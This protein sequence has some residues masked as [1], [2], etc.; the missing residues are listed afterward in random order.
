MYKRDLSIELIS[1]AKAYPVVTLIGPR[2]AGKSTLARSCFPEMPYL[3]LEDPEIRRYAVEDP[4][5]FLAQVPQGAILDE[6][7]NVP[8]LLSYIQVLVDEKKQNGQFILTGSHQLSLHGAISQSLAGRTAILTLLPLSIDELQ[9]NGFDLQAD[10]LILNGGYPRVYEQHLDPTRAYADYYRTYVQR[11][12]RQMIHVKDLNLFEKFVKL[13]AGRIGSIFSASSLANEVGVSNN[14][15]NNWLSI[16][17]ASFIIFRLQP[18]FESFGKRV[19]KSPK[20]YFT[21]VGLAAYLLDIENMSQL[22]RDPLRGALFENL[23][24]LEMIKYRL[25]QGAAPN[26]YYYRD[27]HKN[28][29]DLVVKYGHEL[30]PVEIKSAETFHRDFLKAVKFFKKVTGDRSPRGYVVYAGQHTQQ[31]QE[32]DVINYKDVHS[33]WQQS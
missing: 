1:S 18:Y 22:K 21:D 30:I 28:E 23:V 9:K 26:I 13:C 14:T 27:N 31:V 11:D 25:N 29:I 20:L 17:E 3:N 2:Q 12:V 4:R 7:Q 10:K 19:I 33:I 24:V 15:I 6:I 16:M 8:E 32:V 5:S